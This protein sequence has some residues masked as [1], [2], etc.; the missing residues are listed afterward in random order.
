MRVRP[1]EPGA[2]ISENTLDH[3]LDALEAGLDA[4]DALPESVRVEVMALLD[5]VDALHRAAIVRLAELIG[6]EGVGAL[7]G[8]P[9]V[10]WLLDAYGIGLDQE[11]G[12]IAALDEVRP[13]VHSHGGAID[14]VGVEAG[15]V[16]LRL[17]GTCAGCTAAAETLRDRVEAALSD[18]V[19][20][21][22]ALEAEPDEDGVE[23]HPPPPGP[24]AVELS[25]RPGPATGS[26]TP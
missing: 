10:A 13:Y 4:V 6:A 5:G 22:V 7:R 20:G 17:S 1:L 9:L 24:V 19:P 14:L 25:R 2:D 15:V 26:R 8:D 21:F 12:A 11:T 16:R 23:P 18:H 3:L